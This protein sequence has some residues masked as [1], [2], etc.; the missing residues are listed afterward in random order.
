MPKYQSDVYLCCTVYF[1]AK[2]AKEAAAMIADLSTHEFGR[3]DLD[4]G[5]GLMMSPAVTFYPEGITEQNTK[6][7][8]DRS[9]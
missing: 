5:D 1:E 7:S 8:V 6:A 4:L 9:E 3:R 2:N